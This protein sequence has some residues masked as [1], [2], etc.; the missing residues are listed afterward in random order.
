MNDHSNRN[1]GRVLGR[2]LAVEETLAVSGAKPTSPSADNG[3]FPPMDTGYVYDI[4]PAEDTRI[5]PSPLHGA[6]F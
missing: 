6:R 3:T 1:A 2:T 5:E 4:I